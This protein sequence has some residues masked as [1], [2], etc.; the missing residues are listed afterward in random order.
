M[1]HEFDRIKASLINTDAV[2]AIHH[3]YEEI[4]ILRG[5]YNYEFDLHDW[6]FVSTLCRLKLKQAIQW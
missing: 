6:I 2:I 1:A 5:M 4:S 3:L